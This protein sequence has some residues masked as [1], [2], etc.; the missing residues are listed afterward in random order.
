MKKIVFKILMFI[1][2][3][4]RRVR[5]LIATRVL[6]M[7]AH[8]MGCHVRVARIPY[9]ASTVTVDIGS[10]AG[11]NGITIT[12]MG[13]VKVGNYFHSGTNVKIQLGSHDYDND[14][15]IPYGKRYTVKNVI[16]DDFVW[17]GSDVTIC[18]NVHI[19]EGAIVAIGSVV[20][21]DVPRCAIV[22]GN[23]AKIIKYRDIEHFEKLKADG[24]Y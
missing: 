15:K 21:K 10:H 7:R 4:Y 12:G 14:N 24:K 11:V 1:V 20:V 16:I 2:T 6:R 3:L 18:G 9:I 19:G 17:L 8:S 5:S 22:G 13:G 23:P